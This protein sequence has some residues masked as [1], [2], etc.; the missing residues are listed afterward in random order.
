MFRYIGVE[1]GLSGYSC[2]KK[3]GDRLFAF[4][5]LSS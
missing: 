1:R 2:Q 3:E 5:T 4:G